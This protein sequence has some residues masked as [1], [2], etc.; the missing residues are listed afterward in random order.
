MVD[1]NKWTKDFLQVL[2]QIFGER[3]Y[4]AG[5]QGSYGRGE[6]TE[7]SDIDMVVILDRLLPGVIQ[8]SLA[9]GFSAEKTSC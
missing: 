6:A 2:E 9:A 7:S 4:F 1:I 8:R 3:V 5:L